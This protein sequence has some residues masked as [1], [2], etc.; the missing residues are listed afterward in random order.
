[1][2]SKEARLFNH[3]AAMATAAM[4][5]PMASTSITAGRMFLMMDFFR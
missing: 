1:V 4:P 3:T 5:M 2:V